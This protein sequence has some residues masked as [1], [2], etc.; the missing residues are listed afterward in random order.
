MELSPAKRTHV[1]EYLQEN[2]LHHVGGVGR[3]VQQNG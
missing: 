2:F 3:I 1:P